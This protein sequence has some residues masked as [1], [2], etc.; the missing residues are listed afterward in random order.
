MQLLVLF[1]IQQ[2]IGHSA[3]INLFATNIKVIFILHFKL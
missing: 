3:Y 2:Y 1:E